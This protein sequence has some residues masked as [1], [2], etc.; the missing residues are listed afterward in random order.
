[1]KNKSNADIRVTL[2]SIQKEAQLENLIE[3]NE[4]IENVKKDIVKKMKEAIK[5]N[6]EVIKLNTDIVIV[7]ASSSE[8]NIKKLINILTNMELHYKISKHD[9]ATP[10]IYIYI[11]N[12]N[13]IDSINQK[14]DD[15]EKK[16]YKNYIFT[17][18][19]IFLAIIFW[20]CVIMIGCRK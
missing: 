18:S 11:G 16:D 15:Y 10:G 19:S 7:D 12:D 6:E 17:V 5:S 14:I 1:M 4:R 9:I 20:I 2:N 8:E 13:N 3:E